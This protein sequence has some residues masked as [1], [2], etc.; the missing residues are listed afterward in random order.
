MLCHARFLEAPELNHNEPNKSVGHGFSKDGLVELTNH[1]LVFYTCNILKWSK[2]S[3]NAVKWSKYTN[4]YMKWNYLSNDI[5]LSKCNI[6]WNDMK[7]PSW[8]CG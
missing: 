3:N 4:M 7:H 2:C 8:L 6:T 5:K 1:F